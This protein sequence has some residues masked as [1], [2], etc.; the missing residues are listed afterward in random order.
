LH[1]VAA[2][3]AAFLLHHGF[4]Q[5]N[6]IGDAELFAVFV[7][8]FIVCRDITRQDIGF[9]PVEQL[10]IPKQ[11]TLKEWL[12]YWMENVVKPNRQPTTYYYYE[13]IINKYTVP[14]LGS[15]PIQDLKPIQIQ[16]YYTQLKKL[17]PTQLESIM[18][19]FI[20]R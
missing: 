18:I 16:K 6:I 15:I 4:R 20:L 13:G 17:S 9:S 12:D 7:D 14:L 8:N 5:R 3:T 19:C 1:R 10:V 11:T 2:E